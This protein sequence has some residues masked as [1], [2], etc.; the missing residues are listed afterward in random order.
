[1][2]LWEAP[3]GRGV[4]AMTT[5]KKKPTRTDLLIV[6]GRLQDAIGA[7]RA[8]H[9]ADTEQASFERAQKTL[10]DAFNLCVDAM[11]FDPPRKRRSRN[12]WGES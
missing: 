4:P 7:A 11:S 8:D 10:A 12:G 6:V 3:R 9:F 5:P 1:M 2:R